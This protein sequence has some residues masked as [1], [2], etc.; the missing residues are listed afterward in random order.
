MKKMFEVRENEICVTESAL[1]SISIPH[2]G[3]Y[4]VRFSI[5]KTESGYDVTTPTG[6]IG[7]PPEPPAETKLSK[8]QYFGS[9]AAILLVAAIAL[10]VLS[11]L[12]EIR[13][14]PRRQE[15]QWGP[16]ATGEFVDDYADGKE[17]IK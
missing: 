6:S 15:K 4:E 11:R 3:W 9:T 12:S 17:G 1:D 8:L 2:R 13:Q 16:S 5:L 10:V 7:V 14:P